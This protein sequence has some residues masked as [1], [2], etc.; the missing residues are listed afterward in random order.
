MIARSP[1]LKCYIAARCVRSRTSQDTASPVQRHQVPLILAFLSGTLLLSSNACLPV[2]LICSVID[3]IHFPCMGRTR[4]AKELRSSKVVTSGQSKRSQR[5]SIVSV[6]D[7]FPDKVV[8][9]N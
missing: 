3:G 2:S 9:E 5:T 4:R 1:I 7:D 6:E 8:V